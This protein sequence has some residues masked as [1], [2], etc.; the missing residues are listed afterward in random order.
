MH[1]ILFFLFKKRCTRS[2]VWQDQLSGWILM[3]GN[4]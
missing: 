1:N 2:M 4:Q 3:T